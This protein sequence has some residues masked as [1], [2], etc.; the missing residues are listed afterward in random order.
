MNQRANRGMTLL[1]LL[2]GFFLLVSASIIFFQ[3][4][5]SFKKETTFTSEN[6]LAASLTEKVLEQCYQEADL[7]PH[8]L[9]AMVWPM[10]TARST[11]FRPL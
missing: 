2:I 10:P 3:A 4:M 7:N 9:Q 1:E 11:R 5:H 6:F 8:G